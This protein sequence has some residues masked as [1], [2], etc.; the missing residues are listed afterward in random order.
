MKLRAQAPKL[1]TRKQRSII[2]KKRENKQSD[3]ALKEVIKSNNIKL[4]QTISWNG[5]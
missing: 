1:K 2:G 4:E 5:K 3:P